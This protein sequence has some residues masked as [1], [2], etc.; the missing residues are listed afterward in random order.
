MPAAG[1]GEAR[2]RE[3]KV[4]ATCD[5][6]L[7]HVGYILLDER[8]ES[9]PDVALPAGHRRYVGLNRRI[10]VGLR[11]PRVTSSFPADVSRIADPESG[12]KEL[13]TRN[14][15]LL[16]GDLAT[17][18]AGGHGGATAPAARFAEHLALSGLSTAHGA[19][20]GLFGILT[21]ASIGLRSFWSVGPEG[22]RARPLHRLDARATAPGLITAQPTG[23]TW[24]AT[25]LR[26][27]SILDR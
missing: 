22:V 3:R 13:V 25:V 10:A 27:I 11:D 19:R 8:V 4:R 16:E 21:G 15:R 7:A 26:F 20:A 18:R 24:D 23:A 5:N 1:D 17:H 9:P 2:Y 14:R 12:C 6:G